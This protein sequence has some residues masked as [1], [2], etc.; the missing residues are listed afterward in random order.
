MPNSALSEKQQELETT[1]MLWAQYHKSRDPELREQLILQYAPLVKYVVG[2]MA[3]GMPAVVD[4]GDILS[5]G[6]IGLI[7]ALERYDPGRGIKF[8]TYAIQRVRGSIIDA[9]RSLD[10]MSCNVGKRSR[11]IEKA[12][13]EL[14]QESGQLPT[15]QEIAHRLGLSPEQYE[16]ALIDA[17]TSV[18]S[19]DGIMLQSINGDE[20]ITLLD[21]LR[22]KNA[23]D[24]ATTAE[25]REIRE[26]LINAIR[27]LPPREYLIVSLYYYDE[28]T[29]KEIS[30]LLE[31]SESRVCQ[32][33]TQAMLK[34]RG[35][36]RAAR[37]GNPPDVFPWRLRSIYRW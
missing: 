3:V 8:E 11:A 10:F 14:Q 18:V 7:D 1:A 19:L 34:L 33:R 23:P 29:L 13:A 25:G 22:C 15:N 36:L 5:H 12:I 28:L 27:Q 6:M 17:N 37:L 30:E 4:S 20:L 9:L 35:A 21:T 24:P 31:I 26:I 32:L 16:Q 2:R